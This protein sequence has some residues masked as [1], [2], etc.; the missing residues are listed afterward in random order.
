MHHAALTFSAS[1]CLLSPTETRDFDS[2]ILSFN[3]T[4]SLFLLAPPASSSHTVLASITR[5]D[6]PTVSLLVRALMLRGLGLSSLAE[7]ARVFMVYAILSSFEGELGHLRTRAEAVLF[8]S[9]SQI[10]GQQLG[11]QQ[12]GCASWKESSVEAK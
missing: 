10:W 7:G 4:D 1:P 5:R 2:L 12:K 8:S 3:T 11:F 9:D 6:L